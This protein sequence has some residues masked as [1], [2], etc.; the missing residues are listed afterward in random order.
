MKTSKEMLKDFPQIKTLEQLNHF[1][2]GLLTLEPAV[3]KKGNLETLI[4]NSFDPQ[5]A[6]AVK[7][8]LNQEQESAQKV[9]GAVSRLLEEL[10]STII[11]KLEIAVLPS[12]GLVELI[13]DSVS[14]TVKKD[15]VIDLVQKEEILG[16]V[17]I[18]VNGTSK[19]YSLYGQF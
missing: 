18:F 12:L 14:Q 7:G 5:T 19:D 1:K 6:L 16:G 15:F 13:T 10:K 9:S 2:E 11:I 4:K 8:Y 17:V 3:F